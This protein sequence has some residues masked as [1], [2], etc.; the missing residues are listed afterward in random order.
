MQELLARYKYRGEEKL[1]L[2]LGAMLFPS[3][4]RLSCDVVN[5]LGIWNVID[6]KSMKGKKVNLDTLWDAITY[7]P[8]SV[9]RAEERGFNQSERLAAAISN[10]YGIPLFHLLLRK[11]HSVKQSFKTR[12]ERLKDM[13]NI[14]MVDPEGWRELFNHPSREFRE[15][16]AIRLL[17]IDDIYTTGSTI[18]ACSKELYT[19]SYGKIEIYALTWARS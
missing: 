16:R 3:I 2:Y 14:F 7:V 5:R 13:Q 4:E 15:M 11:K 6:S 8:V 1:E 19:C 18:Q 10:K 9:E 17:L 12:S